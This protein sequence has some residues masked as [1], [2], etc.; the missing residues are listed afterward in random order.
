MDEIKA[1]A[2]PRTNPVNLIFVM[3]QYAPKISELHFPPPRDFFDLVMRSSLGS[4]SRAKAFLWLIWWYLESNFTKEDAERN[5]FGPG[6]LDPA[7]QDPQALPLKV[8]TLE[9]LTEEQAAEENVDTEEEKQFGEIKRKERIAILASEPSPAMTALKRARKEKGLTTGHG[10]HPSDD[11]GSE[12]GSYHRGAMRELADSDHVDDRLTS[13]PAASV[14]KM[15]TL[16][17]ET[18]SDY[19]RSPS[20]AGSRGFQAVSNKPVG[21][22][23]INNLLNSDDIAPDQSPP[24]AASEFVAPPPKKGPGRGNWRRNKTKDTSGTPSGSRF[25]QDGH[26]IPLLP[27]NGQQLDFINDGPSSSTAFQYSSS[28]LPPASPTQSHSFPFARDHIPT[29]SYQAQKRHRGVTQHQSAVMTHRKQQIDYTLDRRIRKAQIVCRNARESGSA[30][31]RAWKR[32]RTLPI[33]YDSEEEAIK[34]RKARDRADKTDDDWRGGVHRGRENDDF[35][36]NVDLWRRPRVLLAGFVKLPG[37]PSDVGEEVRSLAKSFR[38]ASRRL[39]RWGETG[40]P[41]QA[42]ISRRATLDFGVRRERER[43]LSLEMEDEQRPAAPVVKAGTK[44]RRPAKAQQGGPTRKRA[45]PRVKKE[46]EIVQEMERE[47]EEVEDDEN[48]GAGG[49]TAAGPELD[50][51]DREMLGEVDADESEEDDGDEMDVDD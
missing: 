23:R 38:R 51:E 48:G 10:A 44:R 8:P 30:L 21:D 18:A 24:Q 46:E 31:I 22:M 13:F 37:E 1:A 11:E 50:E 49:A 39:Q 33:D 34:V 40:L 19:T 27:N 42:V 20:P 28:K 12:V 25:T 5:P 15:S 29:P 26:H 47:P 4:V 43:E 41:G 14:G 3:S 7:E 32:I 35:L 45:A 16:Q 17:F 36:D 9:S 2:I 6:Q